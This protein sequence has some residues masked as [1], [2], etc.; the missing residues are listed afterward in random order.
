VLRPKIDAIRKL[1]KENGRDPRSIKFFATFTTIV[2]ATDGEAQVKHDELKKYAST[3]G[4]LVLV[5]RRT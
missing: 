5:S 2:A 1:A 3:E 4:G